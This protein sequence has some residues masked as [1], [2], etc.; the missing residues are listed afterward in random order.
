MPRAFIYKTKKEQEKTLEELQQTEIYMGAKDGVVHLNKNGKPIKEG[1]KLKRAV[2]STNNLIGRLNKREELRLNLALK[3]AALGTATDE[4][5][6]IL[7]DHF[8]EMF[9]K[10]TE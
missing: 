8:T 9:S 3:R 1:W 6:Q 2:A 10:L 7:E 5:N 4:D